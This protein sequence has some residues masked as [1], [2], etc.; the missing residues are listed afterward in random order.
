MFKL[1]GIG[2]HHLQEASHHARPAL[3]TTDP[4]VPGAKLDAG[5]VRMELLDGFAHALL[6]IGEVA[7]FGAA[8]YTDDG[9]M[10]VPDAKRRYTGAL[11]RHHYQATAGESCDPESGLLHAAH[12]AWNALALL[13]LELRAIADNDNDNDN[14][15]V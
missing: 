1:L 11:L 12:R 3:H 2:Q 14:A 4:H 9:W 7:T 15:E 8:K 6:H 13:E 5:K 10:H